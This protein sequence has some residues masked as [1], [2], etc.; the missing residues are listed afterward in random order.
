MRETCLEVQR[1]VLMSTI[2]KSNRPNASAGALPES[3]ASTFRVMRRIETF[4]WTLA[5]MP[6]RL[7]LKSG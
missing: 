3:N 4:H 7:I 1:V 6:R 5:V 2:T